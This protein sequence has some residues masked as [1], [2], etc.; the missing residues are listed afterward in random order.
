MNLNLK[1]VLSPLW[2][3]G[4][5]SQA[6][7]P[8]SHSPAPRSEPKIYG[9]AASSYK[10]GIF[11]VSGSSG[12]CTGTL[13]A[14]RTILTAGHCF[15][16][17]AGSTADLKVYY[18]EMNKEFPIQR[19]R[20]KAHKNLNS[21]TVDPQ[22]F[23]QIAFDLAL[24]T[25][26]DYGEI[27]DDHIQ[28]LI[29]ERAEQRFIEKRT[30][31][32]FFGYGWE[33][34]HDYGSRKRLQEGRVTWMSKWGLFNQEAYLSGPEAPCTG[35]SGGPVLL[36]QGEKFVLAGVTSKTTYFFY[37]NQCQ[38]G[39]LIASNLAHPE[40]QRWIKEGIDELSRF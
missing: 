13:V 19:I 23:N 12:A 39:D 15:Q 18:E 17:E 6:C 27:P 22:N 3:L 26:D 36:Q 34:D 38:P 14:K 25:I 24:I 33:R 32:R 20:V 37:D 8:D 10:R 11:L 40:L 1:K 7:A 9:G 16:D 31:L 4:I 2:L 30:S 29:S 35:D 28:T 21:I 5:L